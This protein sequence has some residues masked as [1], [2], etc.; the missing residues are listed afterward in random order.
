[1]TFPRSSSSSKRASQRIPWMVAPHSH[2]IDAG[3]AVASGSTS[4]ARSEPAPDGTSAASV[5][6]IGGS[7]S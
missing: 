1:M 2:A 4:S 3:A 6:T 5:V 7:H